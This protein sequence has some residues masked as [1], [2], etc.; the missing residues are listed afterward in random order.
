MHYLLCVT[1]KF[2]SFYSILEGKK[3]KQTLFKSYLRSAKQSRNQVNDRALLFE[4]GCPPLSRA[5]L[6]AGTVSEIK[7][8]NVFGGLNPGISSTGPVVWT[9]WFIVMYFPLWFAPG[10]AV[11]I[12]SY[13]WLV[14]FLCRWKMFQIVLLRY[15]VARNSILWYSVICINGQNVRANK[16]FCEN[17]APFVKIFCSKSNILA[18]CNSTPHY[19]I[20]FFIMIY[21]KRY[22]K[23]IPLKLCKTI[24]AVYK[25]QKPNPENQSF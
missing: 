23:K 5:S 10:I 21:R 15:S 9:T 19:V 25:F 20:P 11:L 1:R 12:H 16:S 3:R 17:L 7:L 14:H 18:N 8:I 4:T 6:G 2:F 24:R 13:R 22:L